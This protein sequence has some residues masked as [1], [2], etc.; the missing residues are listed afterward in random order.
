M[1]RKPNSTEPVS[2]AKLRQKRSKWFGK[3]DGYPKPMSLM[4]LFLLIVLMSVYVAEFLK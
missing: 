3:P 4:L 2:H 1:N